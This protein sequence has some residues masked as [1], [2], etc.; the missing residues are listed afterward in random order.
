[1]NRPNPCKRSLALFL[2]FNCLIH[3]VATKAEEPPLVP[4]EA[5]IG[6]E[7]INFAN[8]EKIFADRSDF[9]IVHSVHMSN[10]EGER[11][12]TITVANTASGKRILSNQHLLALFA[13][14]SR[15]YPLHFSE[16]FKARETKSLLIRFET[17]RFPI[18]KIM[19]R[20]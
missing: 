19:T 18:L 11:W 3:S 7:L 14:G 15:R 16:E 13:D 2:V 5:I 6:G 4:D 12:A 9:T 20:Q 1:M 10:I 8:D 17:D